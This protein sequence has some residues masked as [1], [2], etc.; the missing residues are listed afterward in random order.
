MTNCT[1]LDTFLDEFQLLRAKSGPFDKMK[2][3]LSR[4][5]QGNFKDVLNDHYSAHKAF[6]SVI[7][8]GKFHWYLAILIIG[9]P[10]FQMSC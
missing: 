10:K 5:F 4:M 2:Q 8:V 7:L 1:G 6:Y 3:L 9:L